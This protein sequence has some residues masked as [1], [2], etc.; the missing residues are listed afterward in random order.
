LLTILKGMRRQNPVSNRIFVLS[1]PF[2]LSFD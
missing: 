1:F 2:E